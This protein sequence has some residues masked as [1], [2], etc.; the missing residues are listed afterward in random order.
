MTEDQNEKLEHILE[1]IIV[2]RELWLLQADAGQYALLGDDTGRSFMPVWSS[3]SEAENAIADEWNGY[4]VVSMSITEFIGWLGE[5]HED[6]VYLGFN[7][8]ENNKILALDALGL[9]EYLT[10]RL[11]KS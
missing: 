2:K 7:P 11:G 10:T 6:Q 1:E 9:K 4:E 5:L 3:I 8:D